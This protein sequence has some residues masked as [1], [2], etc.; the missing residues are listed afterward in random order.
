MDPRT[1]ASRVERL[2]H[3][4][5][6]SLSLVWRRKGKTLALFLVYAVVVFLPASVLFLVDSLRGMS[7]VLLREGPE[8]V[9]QRIV[10][11]RHDLFPREYAERIRAIPGVAAAR[12]RLWGYYYDP[13]SQANY[14]FLAPGD[15]PADGTMVLGDG[16]S[17]DRQAFPG[18]IMS[19][20]TSG[21]RTMSLVVEQVLPGESSLLTADLVLVSERDF[22]ELFGMPEGYSTDLAVQV[23]A[24][25]DMD[26]VAREI[27]ARQPD[28]RVTRR[29]DVLRTYDGLFDWRGGILAAILAFSALAFLVLIWD[30]A[31]GL[32]PEER[33]EIGVLRAIGWEASDV[34]LL[35]V[36]EGAVV[37]IPA[38]L[39][40][41]LLAYAHVFP[42]KAFLIT[43]VL[44]GW[45][46]LYPDFLLT[47]SVGVG[48][49]ALLFGLTVVP[50]SAVAAVAARGAIAAD[51]DA[52]MR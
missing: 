12:E 41:T 44:K 32:P 31:S 38:F 14:S 2:R 15:P 42:G 22:R 43:P 21:G 17:K 30:K 35:K 9:V 52:A 46:T 26:A 40:G 1:V 7:R 10:M 28:A 11:G 49:I 36:C 39:C 29:D 33:G 48:R 20:R 25:A 51:P 13:G 50:Y 47:P 45:S 19:F 5:D 16:I 3:I 6:L 34:L 8:I 37:S 23:R 24:P 18:D 4:L 27:P